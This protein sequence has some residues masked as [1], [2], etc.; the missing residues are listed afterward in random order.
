MPDAG[1][2]GIRLLPSLA[3]Y[4]RTWLR[5]DVVAGVAAGCLIIPQ[6]MAYATIA[7]MPVEI[8]STPASSRWSCT[9]CWAARTR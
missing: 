7:E 2:R 5:A 4:R 8:G 3:G 1:P 6:A 9:P